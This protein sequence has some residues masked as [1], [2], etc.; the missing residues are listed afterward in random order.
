MIPGKSC[1][2]LVKEFEGCYLDAYKDPIGIPTIGIGTIKYPDGRK[3]KMGDKITLK[4][5]EELLMH[6]LNTKAIAIQHHFFNV[7]INQN[8]F[9]ALLSFTYNLGVG[10]LGKSTLLKKVKSNHN[11]PS[12]RNEFMKW[13]R[14]GGRVL[15]GLVRRRKA[16]ADLYFR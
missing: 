9:D 4:Q 16:E 14:A 2:E 12:I 7:A 3:V 8:Q 11:D 15:P 6:E 5:A 10:A 13:V 1:I